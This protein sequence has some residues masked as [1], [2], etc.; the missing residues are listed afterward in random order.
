MKMDV[1]IEG[2]EMPVGV[3]TRAEDKTLSF[4]YAEGVDK[5]G[6]ISLSVP[7]QSHPYGDADCRGHFAN[8]LFEGPQL[9]HILS[10]FKVDRDD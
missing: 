1:W 10:S 2:R 6:Q 3:L 4:V 5:G 7:V 8:L 9:D